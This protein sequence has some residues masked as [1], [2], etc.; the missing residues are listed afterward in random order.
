MHQAELVK[1]PRLAQAVAGVM[2]QVQGLVLASED[3]G[4]VSG[5][6]SHGAE[7]TQR[8]GLV[9]GRTNAAGQG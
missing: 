7:L 8:V 3:G 1:G 9:E 4:V 6:P 2:E 5:Q